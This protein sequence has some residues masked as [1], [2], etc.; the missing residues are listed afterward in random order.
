MVR[1]IF[2]DWFNTLACYEPPREKLHSQALRE[3]GIELSPE[4]ILPGLLAADSYFFEENAISPV[5]R[6]EP[7]KRAEVYMR[8]YNMMLTRVGVKAD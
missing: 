4:E 2:F 1:A 6:R 8:Y 3:F 5:E 7:K